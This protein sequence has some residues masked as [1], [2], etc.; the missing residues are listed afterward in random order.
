MAGIGRSRSRIARSGGSYG[1]KSAV[2]KLQEG[3]KRTSAAPKESLMRRH[4]SDIRSHAPGTAP[5][6]PTL[7]PEPG[8]AATGGR[9]GGGHG[10][11][12]VDAAL[13][14]FAFGYQI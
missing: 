13:D 8:C 14:A 3:R 5:I 10:G 12:R 4:P 11:A 6:G 7:K 1:D 2:L 9:G